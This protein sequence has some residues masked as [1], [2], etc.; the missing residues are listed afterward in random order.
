M[1]KFKHQGD[2]KFVPVAEMPKGKEVKHNGSD[3]L[4]LGETTGHKHVITVARPEMMIIT[5]LDGN[6]FINLLG[7]AVVTHEE[8]S[9][10]ALAPGIY[11]IGAEREVDW[12]AQTTR[13]VID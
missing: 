9:D 7:P 2:V 1:T 10:I 11:R 8:H 5:V 4:A 12:F 13:K 6:K 3:V